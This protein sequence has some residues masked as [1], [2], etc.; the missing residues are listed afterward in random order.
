MDRALLILDLDETLIFASEQELER[1]A[2]FRVFYYHAY[3]RPGLAEFLN[4]IRRHYRIAVWTSS[5]P[6]YGSMVVENIFPANYPLEFVWARDRCTLKRDFS[7]CEYHYIKNLKKAKRLGFPLQRMLI[8]DNTPAKVRLNYGNAVY[9]Q[10]WE[11][12]LNDREL[13]R[14]AKYLWS[15]RDYANYRRLE[16]RGWRSK[17]PDAGPIA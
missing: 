2:D 3:R 11:G 9:V 8:V 15:I 7:M 10:T 4:E 6:D 16:K 14:L 12:D 5:S 13:P 1:P 17:D